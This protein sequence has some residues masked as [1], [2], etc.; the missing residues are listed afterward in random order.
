VDCAN[1]CSMNLNL[2]SECVMF[3]I[4]GFLAI[5]NPL[6]ANLFYDSE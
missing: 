5:L 4:V 6:I 2:S 3:F 1:F